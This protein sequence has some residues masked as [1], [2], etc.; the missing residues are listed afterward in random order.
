MRDRKKES[1]SSDKTVLTR[2]TSKHETNIKKVKDA[3]AKKERYRINVQNGRQVEGHR[4][5][6]QEKE[7][8]IVRKGERKCEE[9]T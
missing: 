7:S 4:R 8:E 5:K 2:N 6:Q 3:E 9:E 1:F